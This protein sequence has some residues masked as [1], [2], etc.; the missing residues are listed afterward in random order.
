[1]HNS[2]ARRTSTYIYA[3][4]ATA[5]TVGIIAFPEDSFRAALDGLAVWWEIEIPALLPFFV[6]SEILMGLGVVHMLGVLLEPLMR[7]MFNV[8]GVGAYALAMGLA[9]G[10]PMGAKITAQLRSKRLCS[11]IEAER[12]VSIT[13]TADPLFMVGAVAVGMLGNAKLGVV[14]VLAHY[15]ASIL[16]GFVMRFYGRR[17]TETSGARPSRKTGLLSHAVNELVSARE[18]DGRSIGHLLGDAVHESVKTLLL[19]GGFIMVFSVVTRIL[20]LA[21]VTHLIAT[22]LGVALRRFGV[23]PSI[24][25]ALVKGFFE[26]TIG[27]QEASM[28]SASIATQLIAISAIIGWSGLSVCAQ[29]ASLVHEA[30]IRLH[31]YLSARVIHAVLS[32]VACALLL[33]LQPFSV[34]AAEL[35]AS[36]TRLVYQPSAIGTLIGSTK[37][38]AGALAVTS[39]CA[40]LVSLPASLRVVRFFYSSKK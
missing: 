3:S 4:I 27:C 14:I 1:M 38:L 9:S 2:H 28:A 30:G 26:I 32:A 33:R 36:A 24:L 31:A 20:A 39:V 18:S 37:L 22:P 35:Q 40:L 12:L 19:V 15:S 25:D 7:P 5:I 16:L 13:N 8:P 10:Y 6:A 29:V 17:G 34:P 21:G 11:R 23:E